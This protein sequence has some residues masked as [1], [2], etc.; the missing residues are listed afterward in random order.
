MDKTKDC[1]VGQLTNEDGDGED[2]NDMGMYLLQAV[3]VLV[4]QLL[5]ICRRGGSALSVHLIIIQRQPPVI[6]TIVIIFMIIIHHPSYHRNH[7]HFPRP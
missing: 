2:G 7:H 5:N 1:R 3:L 6:L 4:L